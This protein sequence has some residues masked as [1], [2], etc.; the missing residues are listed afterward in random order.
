VDGY[1]VLITLETALSGGPVL[2]CLDGCVRDIASVGARHRHSD[3]TDRALER[4]SAFLGPCPPG[5]VRWLFDEPV[6]GSGD[7]AGYVRRVR[8]D[9]ESRTVPDPDGELARFAGVVCSSDAAVLDRAS[10]WIDL[11]GEIIRAHLPEAWL[12]DLRPV[13]V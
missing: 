6:S 11:A 4:V 10:Q 8:P 5:S 7:L 12:L 2:A 3:H 13:Q 1:N 9:W